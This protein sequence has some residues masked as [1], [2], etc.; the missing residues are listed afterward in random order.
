MGSGDRKILCIEDQADTCDMFQIVLPEFELVS[1]KSKAEGVRFAHE[2]HFSL[3]ILDYYLPDGNGDE[4]CGEI[5]GF[6]QITPI[7]FV[8]GSRSF[9]EKRARSIGAQGMVKKASL[10]FIEQIQTRTTEMA[11]E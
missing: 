6:D 2:R 3:I 8:T 7:L 4:V 9:T 5:R 10:T 1:A 11:I